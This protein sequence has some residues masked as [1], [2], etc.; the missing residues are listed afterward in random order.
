MQKKNESV[1]QRIIIAS[2]LCSHKPNPFLQEIKPELNE[3]IS[4]SIL[5]KLTFLGINLND[6]FP[7][8]K[9]IG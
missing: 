5:D 9:E 4:L 2:F 7:F 1:E 3:R 8:Q 6:I